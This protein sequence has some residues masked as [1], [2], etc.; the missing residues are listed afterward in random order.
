M[1]QVRHLVS[2]PSCKKQYDVT[3]AEVGLI[4]HCACG[5]AVTI[6]APKM[7]DAAVIRCSNCGAPRT[8]GM[9]TCSFCSSEFTLHELDMHTI[10]PNCATRVSDKAKFCHSCSTPLAPEGKLGERTEYACPVCGEEKK[11]SRR[12]LGRE[13]VSVLECGSCGGL[14]LSSEVFGALTDKARQTA[15]P[16]ETRGGSVTFGKM[17]PKT[18][19]EK[20][21]QQ[22]PLYRK[23][24]VCTRIMNRVNYGRQSGV[25]IDMCA[26]HGVWFDNDEL[27]HLLQW[28]RSGGLI[29]SEER[30]RVEEKEVIKLEIYKQSHMGGGGPWDDDFNRGHSILTGVADIITK[31]FIS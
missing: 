14:W 27:T 3:G 23:C 15:V 11:L 2:C 28:I 5:E 13:N 18:R 12:R 1:T 30:R 22:G 19:S 29:A 21:V 16:N 26:D 24:L 20:P 8:K 10:C 6:S 7:H 31:I 25:I 4:F 17:V 9:E